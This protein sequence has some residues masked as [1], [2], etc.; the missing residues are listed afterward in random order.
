MPL[1]ES[2]PRWPGSVGFIRKE[3]L[4]CDPYI[5]NSIIQ[6]DVHCGTHIDGQ[7][8]HILNGKPV[9]QIN[10]EYCIGPVQ[11][12]DLT[13]QNMINLDV[14]T[15]KK[16]CENIPRIL[17][18][19]NNSLLWSEKRCNIPSVGLSMEA[20]VWLLKHN[21]YLI[22]IDWLSIQRE[23]EYP[24]VHQ[25]LLKNEVIIL[26]GLNLIDVNS[27]VYDLICLP[28]KIEGGEAAPTR[29]ILVEHGMIKI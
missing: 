8:H 27:G 20:A 1:S 18:K 15:K 6:M 25:Y 11:V 21:V 24:D 9:D 7:S 13:D 5:K 16:F 26:E 12:L 2:I 10:L 3:N 29:V 22:G 4:S 17:F 14:L 23:G 19:T 28:L